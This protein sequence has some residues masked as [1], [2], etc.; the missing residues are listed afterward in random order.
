MDTG[1][2]G[3]L[4]FFARYAYGSVEPEVP[5][6]RISG[7]KFRIAHWLSQRGHDP[8]PDLTD[9]HSHRLPVSD[10]RFLVFIR[11]RILLLTVLSGVFRRQFV[12][13]LQQGYLLV[14]RRGLLLLLLHHR[15][16]FL[17]PFLQFLLFGIFFG[18][19]V[20]VAQC[21]VDVPVGICRR[22]YRRRSPISATHVAR[23][24][25]ARIKQVIIFLSALVFLSF[26]AFK[27]RGK[28]LDGT[29]PLPSLLFEFR[30]LV[31]FLLVP[32][33]GGI[34]RKWH[35]GV[36]ARSGL[37]RSLLLCRRCENQPHGAEKHQSH[38]RIDQ[39]LL[40]LLPLRLRQR[41]FRGVPL[42]PVRLFPYQFIQF[43]RRRGFLSASCRLRFHNR[44]VPF[45]S[46]NG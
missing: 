33:N 39:H 30:L 32:D 4:A 28:V 19:V 24:R 22:V 41:L 31:G 16:Q 38:K 46:H 27:Q 2:N 34:R 15:L 44:V 42:L 23:R 3:V 17:H 8:F 7:D 6:I 11:N 5:F 21:G 26:F 43:H 37:F 40:S 45:H 25:A 36:E 14:H 1:G 12:G 9:R 29:V 18:T 13:L 35:I 20:K 10:C